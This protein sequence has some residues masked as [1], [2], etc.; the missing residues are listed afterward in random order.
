MRKLT[1][2]TSTIA[3]FFGFTISL[4]SQLPADFPGITTVKTGETASGYTFLTVSADVEEIG[5]YIMMIDDDGVPFKHKKLEGDYSYDFK[6][7]PSGLLSYAQFL[8]HHSYTGGG[9]CI[10]MVMDENMEVVDSLQLKNG[11]IAEAHDFQLLPNGHYMA[12][13]YY[14]TQ[15][16]LSDLVDGGYPNAYVSG[17]I[18][19]ELDQEKNVVW[20]WRSWDHYDVEDHIFGRRSARQTVSAFHLNTI[21]LDHDGHMLLATPSWSRKINRQ[22][23]EVMWTLGGDT[24]EFSFVGVDSTEGSGD[25]TGHTFHR[26]ENGNILIYDN[27]PRTGSGTSEAHEYSLDEENLIATKI[28]TFTPSDDI[29][30]WHRGSAQ[31]LPNGNTMVGWGGASGD[32]IPTATEYDA[33]GNIVFEAFFDNPE[34]ES[35][36]AVRHLFPSTAKY[37]ASFDEIAEGSYAFSQG[38]SLDI[39]ITI[40]VDDLVSVGYSELIVK[41]F[42][43]SPQFP[44]FEGRSPMVMPQRV[45]V[46]ETSLNFIE[47]TI[48][49]HADTFGIEDPENITIYFRSEDSEDG[50]FTAL[51]TTYNS[52]TK[53]IEAEFDGFGQFIFTYPD[54]EHLQIVPV[55]RVPEDGE[56]VNYQHPL[57]IEWSQE[58]FHN[59]FDLQVATDDGFSELVVDETGLKS[60]VYTI[61]ELPSN[62]ALFWRVRMTNESGT[63]D[64]SEVFSLTT[65]APYI[66]L[67]APNGNLIWDRGL[68]YFIEWES[69]FDE[70]VIIELYKDNVFHSRIDSVEN[71]NGYQW[72]IPVETDSACNYA[73]HLRSSLNA[74]VQDMSD[75]TFAINATPC[76]D[77]EVAMIEVLS[78]NG[79]EIFDRNDDI[80]ISWDNT[81][82]E[83]VTVELMKDGTSV[84]TLFSG[85][86]ENNVS[87]TVGEDI[88]NATGYTIKITGEGSIA[89]SDEGNDAFELT[90][91]IIGINLEMFEKGFMV[92]PNPASDRIIIECEL[93]SDADVYITLLDMSGRTQKQIDAPGTA[94]GRQTFDIGLD[95]LDEGIYV[96][97]IR[98]DE[99]TAVRSIQVIK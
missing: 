75:T 19:Q 67:T 92:Y 87:W 60:T 64:W 38:D 27:G 81:T 18:V 72:T 48:G 35:Y 89:S 95:S 7:Q 3:L 53:M 94:T 15:F 74:A 80:E 42:D 1:I 90:G 83:A 30:A 39:G 79:G 49:F 6:V 8:S 76:T 29:A 14:L 61:D 98:T 40:D 65:T 56:M 17:G 66:E 91:E 28:K 85:V 59:S 31:R 70:P 21:N 93:A 78:P 2:I 58:G 69:N 46:S 71:I 57:H 84:A 88:D 13:G 68:D 34:V 10:H 9:N 62:E 23:G 51:S 24:N 99:Y 86:S 41:T 36:R 97:R 55:P 63:T 77:V 4:Y 50:V 44:N 12:F 32:P 43:Y 54:F 25:V 33:D 45:E 16:D 26:L 96:V 22:T 82:G 52:V 11:Y 20:Q 37:E 73:I 5:Y 47:G